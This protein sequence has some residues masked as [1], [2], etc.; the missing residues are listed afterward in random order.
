M[1]AIDRMRDIHFLVGA[2]FRSRHQ[3]EFLARKD[4]PLPLLSIAD[5]VGLD[6]V[7]LFARTRTAYT[8]TLIVQY[9]A[10]SMRE[11]F[12]TRTD[13]HSDPK[14]PRATRIYDGPGYFRRK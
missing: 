4:Y 11:Y 13:V 3:F 10:E 6:V 2:S 14:I 7:E 9:N 1:H 5:D 8:P 12:F